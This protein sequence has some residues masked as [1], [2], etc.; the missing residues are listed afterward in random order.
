LNATTTPPEAEAPE[1]D[2][3]IGSGSIHERIARVQRAVRNMPKNKTATIKSQRTGM[4]YSYD[5][6]DKGALEAE[7]RQLLSVEG[8]AIWISEDSIEQTGNRCIVT[9]T[10]TLAIN[11]G[12]M[13]GESFSIKRSGYGTDDSDK[14][15]AKA[16]TTAVRL[17]LADLLLQGGDD[18]AEH[19]YVEYRADVAGQAL[20]AGDRPATVEQLKLAGDLVCRAQLDRAMPT[21]LHAVLRLSRPIAQSEIGPGLQPEEA[22]RLIPLPVM[23]KLIERLETY[24]ANPK[25][26]KAV[27]DKVAEW[28]G[29]NGY[30]N[31]V[32][33]AD[34]LVASDPVEAKPDDTPF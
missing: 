28:E 3:R 5:Y 33:A 32:E 21:P 24:A 20:Q 31:S 4:E 11:D 2:E 8:V 10:I 27:W 19:D 23:S 7:C 26:A 25:G 13:P 17:A 6:I 14:G 34:T 12:E 16:G 29:A 18:V 30:S 9:L 22:V 15:P 1:Y